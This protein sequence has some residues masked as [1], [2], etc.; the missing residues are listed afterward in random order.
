MTLSRCRLFEYKNWDVMQ[1]EQ[2]LKHGSALIDTPQVTGGD[3][4]HVDGL[5]T[6]GNVSKGDDSQE[7]TNVNPNGDGVGSDKPSAGGMPDTK[8]GVN[9]GHVKVEAGVGNQSDL[10]QVEVPADAHPEHSDVVARTGST[11]LP[12]VAVVQ[13]AEQVRDAEIEREIEEMQP[14]TGHNRQHHLLRHS[15]SAD[16]R[17][18]AVLIHFQAE[19]VADAAKMIKKMSQRDLQAKFKAVYGTKTFSNNNNWLRRKLFEAIGMDPGKSTTKKA[20]QT[21]PRRRRTG[22]VGIKA[23]SITSTRKTRP[24]ARY[25]RR[26]KAEVEE[27]QNHVAEA[28]LALADFAC[29]AD[30]NDGM[31]P[32]REEVS[33]GGLSWSGQRDVPAPKQEVAFAGFDTQ[34]PPAPP[35]QHTHDSQEGMGSMMEYFSMMQRLMMQSPENHQMIMQMMAA[36]QGASPTHQSQMMHQMQQMQQIHQMQM[37]MALQNNPALMN[38]FVQAHQHGDT[39]QS[40]H[41]THMHSHSHGHQQQSAVVGH[42][43][44]FRRA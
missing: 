43:D 2:K 27:E 31:V 39:S 11:A 19:S 6:D 22:T 7:I 30:A 3:A 5:S 10:N 14:W 26:S 9:A 41:G 4:G 23:T 29:D 37:L 17:G 15:L 21:G 32:G 42:P 12:P 34:L 38:A 8:I 1:A 24:P 28:L 18:Q 20:T 25:A 13:T 16:E 35:L 36:Q 40:G 44:L 33:D